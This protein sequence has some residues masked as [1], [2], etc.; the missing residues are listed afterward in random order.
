MLGLYNTFDITVF[1]I[2]LLNFVRKNGS[3]LQNQIGNTSTEQL[4]L[5]KLKGCKM[6]KGISNG[7]LFHQLNI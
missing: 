1:M 5:N 4:L 6:A 7:K 2:E 3:V